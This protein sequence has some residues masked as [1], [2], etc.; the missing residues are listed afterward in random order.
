MGSTLG[1]VGQH[2]ARA[3]DA[4]A[5]AN[6]AM[7]CPDWSND[8][9]RTVVRGMFQHL[10]VSALEA[11]RLPV[12]SPAARMARTSVQG[13]EILDGAFRRGRGVVAAT[14]HIGNWEA[15]AACFADLGYPVHVVARRHPNPGLQALIVSLREGYGVHVLDRDRDTRQ[16]LKALHRGEIVALLVD[17][18]TRVQGTMLPFLGRP[19]YTPLGHARLAIRTGAALVVLT[20]ARDSSGRHAVTVWEEVRADESLPEDLRV[21]AMASRCNEILG[22]AIRRTPEQWVWFH[23]RWR[24]E[25]ETVS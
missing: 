15:L 22:Q 23:R 3:E 6:L 8:Q 13:V 11:L 2:L 12:R 9:R 14:G 4:R 1:W 19:A 10:G 17:Q 16:M 25:K 7:V 18:H 20:I 5:R 24:A 21:E